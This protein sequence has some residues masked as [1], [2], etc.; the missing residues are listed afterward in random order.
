MM[1][2][3][4]SF[5][6]IGLATSLAACSTTETWVVIDTSCSSYTAIRGSQHDYEVISEDLAKQILAHNRTWKKKCLKA[7]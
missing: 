6:A 1:R 5:A 3:V 4:K 7:E 2:F